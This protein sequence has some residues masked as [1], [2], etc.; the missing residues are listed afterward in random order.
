MQSV[1]DGENVHRFVNILGAAQLVRWCGHGQEAI[2]FT[3]I[4]FNKYYEHL[5]FPVLHIIPSKMT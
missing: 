3:F 2:C 4:E 5:G 1:G